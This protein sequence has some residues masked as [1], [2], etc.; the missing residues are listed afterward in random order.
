MKYNSIFG[1]DEDSCEQEDTEPELMGKIRTI[2]KRAQDKKAMRNESMDRKARFIHG[3][4]AQNDGILR[5]Y[6]S[7][8][9][10]R[11]GN[12]SRSYAPSPRI[13]LRSLEEIRVELEDEDDAKVIEEVRKILGEHPTPTHPLDRLRAIVVD[14]AAEVLV[15][16]HE[17][18]NGTHLAS[19]AEGIREFAADFRTV[20]LRI[21]LPILKHISSISSP[22]TRLVE[23]VLITNKCRVDDSRYNLWKTVP[24]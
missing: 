9:L 21:A 4:A 20:G 17:K 23:V 16:G 15:R 6:H 11:M 19:L 24:V 8:T 2:V 14:V 10:R 22:T 1:F 7:R 12:R 13:P 18:F 5:G 3:H